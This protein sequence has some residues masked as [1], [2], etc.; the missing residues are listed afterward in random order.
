MRK[1]QQV[2]ESLDLR[3]R[4]EIFLRPAEPE[5]AAGLGREMPLNDFAQMGIQVLFRGFD[6]G[7]VNRHSIFDLRFTM[8]EVA[9]GFRV[10]VL[11]RLGKGNQSEAPEDWRTPR[12]YRAI[13][14]FRDTPRWLWAG[15]SEE[16]R[17]GKE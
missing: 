14:K 9:P 11:W 15:R 6:G 4:V 13:R 17:V 16:R 2:G 3:A 12:R 7:L 8:F 10:L 1:L 5:R